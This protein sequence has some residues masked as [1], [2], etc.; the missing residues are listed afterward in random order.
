MRGGFISDLNVVEHKIFPKQ[1][2]NLR[3][4]LRLGVELEAILLAE[5]DAVREQLSLRGQE[6]GRAARARRELPDVVRNEA[7]QK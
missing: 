7:V 2:F 5:D 1:L 4:E 6:G 3:R